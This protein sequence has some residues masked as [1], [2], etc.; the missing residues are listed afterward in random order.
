MNLEVPSNLVF[1]KSVKICWSAR[2]TTVKNRIQK[3]DRYFWKRK[4]YFNYLTTVKWHWERACLYLAAVTSH[5][6]RS[7]CISKTYVYSI[8]K[9]KKFRAFFHSSSLPALQIYHLLQ[10]A[11]CI[12]PCQGLADRW[13]KRCCVTLTSGPA[14]QKA[15]DA[16]AKVTLETIKPKWKACHKTGSMPS[17]LAAA[18]AENHLKPP[19]LISGITKST[20]SNVICKH[21]SKNEYQKNS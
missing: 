8:R 18:F 7:M 12:S 17:T 6:G 4:S 21:S 5:P 16:F 13:A 10:S 14:L 19:S 2:T 20:E 15:G 11:N 3:Q 9:K 1:Y